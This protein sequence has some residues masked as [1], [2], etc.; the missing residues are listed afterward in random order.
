MT[1][2]PYQVPHYEQLLASLEANSSALDASDTGTGKTYVALAIAKTLGIVPLVV[3]T[4]AG[5][6]GWED[7]STLCDVPVEYINYERLRGQRKR[8]TGLAET[9]WLEEVKWG[10]GS[11][12]K[13]K[14]DYDMVIFDEAHR[15]GGSKSLN[16]KAMIAAR[17]QARYTLA[18]S[19]TAADDPRQMKALGYLLGLHGLSKKS[20]R[21]RLNWMGFQ[22]RHGVTPGV[23]GGYEFSQ[24]PEKQRQVF[25]KLHAEIFPRHGSRMVKAEIP[26]FPKTVIDVKFIED[27]SNEAAAISETLHNTDDSMDG[28]SIATDCRQ[29]LE[30]LKVP[31]FVDLADD[32]SQ[33]SKLVYF[34]NFR[35]PLWKLYE[36]LQKK[37][38][39]DRVGIIDGTQ[40]GERGDAERRDF[41]RRFQ[42]NEL[43]ALCCNAQAGGE[44]AN[45]H[46]PLGHVERTV[47]ISP[48]ESGRQFHQVTGRVNRDGG[49]FSTQFVTLFKNTREEVIAERMRRKSFNVELF[50]D[51]DFKI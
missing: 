43:D 7:A 1:L 22:Y 28:I 10:S 15:C 23:F 4:K 3:G 19:A 39:S 50:N 33:T 9:E 27:E 49:A 34:L 20:S 48:L 16:S 8:E 25:A 29:K 12:L 5:R 17:R 24:D 13:W 6:G 44:S 18:L 47:F 21:Y 36:Q 11:F 41:L 30:L 35:K 37:F 2:R 26:G 31:Y 38:G 14:N 40:T 42:A 32:Y 51:G 45:M 46:D